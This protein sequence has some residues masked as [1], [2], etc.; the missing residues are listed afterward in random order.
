LFILFRNQTALTHLLIAGVEDEVRERLGK[1]TCGKG[2]GAFVQA[3][4]DGGDG[5]GREDVA[6]PRS[7]SVIALTFRVETPC[8]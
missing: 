3:L 1:G 6:W 8:T 5:G 4:V 2:L 7:S